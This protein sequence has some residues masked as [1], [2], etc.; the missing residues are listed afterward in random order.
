MIH[1]ACSSFFIGA[2][3]L[4]AVSRAASESPRRRCNHNFHAADADVCHRLLNAIEPGSYVPPHRHLDPA[5]DETMIVLRGALG[6]V[7]FD[8]S[9]TVTAHARLTPGGDPLAVNIPHGTFHTVL[10]LVPGT[11][12]FESKAGPYTPLAAA[13]KAPWAPLE[14]ADGAATYY[15]ELARS[16]ALHSTH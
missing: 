15:R 12:F 9:G 5:K 11:V 8:A 13:E 2:A 1:P 4:D 3:L 10:G 14:G 7:L 6:V 16:F